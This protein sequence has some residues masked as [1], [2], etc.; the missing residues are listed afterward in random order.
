M[1][2]LT[3]TEIGMNLGL[4]GISCSAAQLTVHPVETS[5]VRCLISLALFD[6]IYS[7]IY[8]ISAL[9]KEERSWEAKTNK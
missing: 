5:M 1:A 9:K 4:A 8:H 2:P 7:K 3:N 6:F